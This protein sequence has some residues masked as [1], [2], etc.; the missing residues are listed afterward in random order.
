MRPPKEARSSSVVGMYKDGVDEQDGPNDFV[1]LK[2]SN[3]SS[4]RVNF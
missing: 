3:I 4:N 1:P 2:E